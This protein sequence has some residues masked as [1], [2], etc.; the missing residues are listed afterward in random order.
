MHYASEAFQDLFEV[1]SGFFVYQK[2]LALMGKEI[3]KIYEPWGAFSTG[4]EELQD[5]LDDNRAEI[6]DL[7]TKRRDVWNHVCELPSKFQDLFKPRGIHQVGFW[8]LSSRGKIIGAIVLGRV[9]PAQKGDEGVLTTCAVQIA[10]ILDM[11][12]AWRV[13]EMK[14]KRYRSLFENNPDGIFEV[15]LE[16]KVTS[17]N[18]AMERITGYSE[19]EMLLMKKG[20]LIVPAEL[21]RVIKH[22]RHV[23]KGFPQTYETTIVHK[24]GSPRY[25]STNEV[26]IIIDGI[27]IGAYGIVKDITGQKEAEKLLRKSEKLAVVGQLAAGVAHEIRN[28]LTALKG[29]TQLLFKQQE[30]NNFCEIMLSELDRINQIVSE[31]LMIAKP[32]VQNFEQEDVPTL[33]QEVVNLIRAQSIL[34]NVEILLS[35]DSQIHSVF[36]D[37]NQLKQVFLNIIKNAIESMQK[38]GEVHVSAKNLD[39]N[40]VIIRI[41]DSGS[42]IPKERIPKLGEPFYTTKEKGTGLG[43]MVSYKIIEAHKGNIEIKS[44]IGKGTSVNITLPCDSPE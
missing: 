38:S 8:S 15:S 11:M 2:Q 23:L 19:S 35:C 6:V 28:P 42:G 26:P 18:Q 22:F 34:N 13:V 44:E 27:V 14:E 17:V 1:E 36:C 39:T 32:Q 43:L 37:R 20:A 5:F 12:K 30:N 31:F 40:R 41:S 33:L 9:N 7:F 25:L 4:M 10:L 3:P 21:H 29:F 16:G 24:D